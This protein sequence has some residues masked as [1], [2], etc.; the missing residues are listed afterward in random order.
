MR[1]CSMCGCS[2]SGCWRGRGRCNEPLLLRIQSLP[3]VRPQVAAL[4]ELI[5]V[6]ISVNPED[7]HAVAHI[8]SMRLRHH[9]IVYGSLKRVPAAA[10][11]D[12]SETVAWQ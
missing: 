10:R 12:G 1:C 9:E 4:H 2:G 11:A 3:R 8:D 5:L 6:T 7:V